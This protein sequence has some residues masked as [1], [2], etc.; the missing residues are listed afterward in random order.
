MVDI[1]HIKQ[2]KDGINW[3]CGL[4]CLEM[5]YN[6]YGI[7]YDSDEVWNTIKSRRPLSLIEF[8]AKT[9]K[10]AL[11]AISH[12]LYAT[13][14]KASSLDTLN[15]IDQLCI[16]SILCITQEKS[17]Q[18]HFIVYTG[19]KHNLFYFCD[20]DSNKLFS[21]MNENK[22]KEAWQENGAAGVTGYI[23]IVFDKNPS[24]NGNCPFCGYSIPIVHSDLINYSNKIV[25]PNCDELIEHLSGLMQLD[26][27]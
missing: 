23:F 21:Y 9:H 25:C 2:S 5:I 18:G 27:S 17:Q 22:M 8:Y 24:H 16:P 20:P 19:K 12:G 14:Y 7:Q 6:Y 10:L 3:K 26:H 15:K 11:D 1:I 4:A 13:I